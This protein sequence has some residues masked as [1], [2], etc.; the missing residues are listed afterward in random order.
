MKKFSVAIVILLLLCTT[1]FSQTKITLTFVAK[2]SV[3]EG[4]IS[5]DSVLVKNLTEGCDTTIYGL[6]PSLPLIA[7]WPYGLDEMNAIHSGGIIVQQNYPNP[8]SGSTYVNIYREYAGPMNLF[9]FDGLG[10]KLSEYRGEFEKGFHSFMISSQGNKVLILSVFD[11]RISRS[12]K[13][14]SVGHGNDADKIQYFGQLADVEYGMVKSSINSSFKFYLGH[15]MK[16]TFYTKGYKEKTIFDKPISDSLYCIYLA[17]F[18]FPFVKTVPVTQVGYNNATGG[19]NVISGGG[20]TVTARGLCWSTEPNPTTANRHSIDGTGSGEFSS[21][22]IGLDSNTVYFVRAYATNSLGTSYGN[23]MTFF[24]LGSC[25]NLTIKHMTGTVAPVDKTVTYGTVANVPGETSKCWITS[26]LGADHQAASLGDNT[27]ASAGWYW[28]FNRKQGF[29]HDGTTRTPNTIWITSINENSNWLPANDP[30]SIEFG[31]GWRI[32]TSTEWSNVDYAGGWNNFFGT[33]NSALKLHAAGSLNST[34]GSIYC[35]GE[36][37]DYSSNGQ[38]SDTQ[39]QCLMF[40]FQY[41]QLGFMPKS[42]GIPI[43]CV[44][45]YLIPVIPTVITTD[46]SNISQYRSYSGGNVAYDGG[47]IV[48]ARGV[49]WS[50]SPNPTISDSLTTDGT[51]TG[52]FTSILTGLNGNTQYYVRA[53]A[54]NSVGTSYGNQDS[55]TTLSVPTC[56]PSVNITIHH[57]AG[58]LSPVNKTVTYGTV[59]N[60]TGEQFKCWITSNLGSDHQAISVDDSSESSAGWYWQ[61][62]HKQGFKHDGTTRTPGNIWVT[63]INISNWLAS[64]DPCALELGY[65]WRIPTYTEW[66]NVRVGGGWTNWD[67]PWN[68]SL[69]MHAAGHLENGNGS[70]T[71]RGIRGDYWGSTT[72]VNWHDDMYVSYLFFD[73]VKSFMG[74]LDGSNITFGKSIRCIRDY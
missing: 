52:N 72:F 29:K 48:T 32:P 22:L 28:Q 47:T 65:F 3:S 25:G 44:K 51:G 9:L 60:I 68:S 59:T 7:T 41:C 36:Y 4:S 16:Y 45:D 61:Y 55:F 14:V 31:D 66:V 46:V 37:G 33:W 20:S 43:R 58:S 27:E 74:G 6:I 5:I 73:N 12:I 34:N 67:G 38:Y 70:L 71:S 19:G 23:H 15:Q 57:L 2:D 18:D 49:C 63:N 54:T 26:N 35:R 69:K 64:N 53:Y 56:G 39:E 1:V 62:N 13:I 50:T 17:M 21:S 10:M 11:D 30:C 24:T 8:F 42:E 40:V